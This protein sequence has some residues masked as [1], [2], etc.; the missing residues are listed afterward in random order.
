MKAQYKALIIDTVLKELRSKTLIFIL[1]A[2][3]LSILIGQLILGVI[4]REMSAS[5]ALG[6][7]GVDILSINFRILN[8]ISFIIAAV[9]GVSIFK[10][11]F[12]N[13]IIYQYLSFP[14][15]R[16]EYFFCR[17]LGTWALV[18]GYYLYSYCLS[19]VLFSFAFKKVIFSSAHLFSFLTLALYLLL[20]I[21]ISIFFSLL[22]NKIGALFVTFALSIIAAVSYGHFSRL[23]YV[24]YLKDF[25][26]FKGLGAAV[27]M[28]FPRTA[29]LSEESSNL[30][31]KQV[32]MAHI[33]GQITH[34]IV[35]S[36]LYIWLAAYFVKRKDF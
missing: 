36:S 35:I 3:T 23:A 17:V 5:G 28:L 24:D 22:L 18:L 8:S 9:F 31:L 12:Q 16:V 4:N 2:T 6:L 7:V 32:S 14:I 34:L 33:G 29:F 21:F 19:T 25:S 1:V 26:P 10:S 13:N 27:Y 11:D 20:V 30:L 15:S